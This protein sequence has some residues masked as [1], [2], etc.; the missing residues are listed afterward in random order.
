MDW[1]VEAA[2]T[3]LSQ[4]WGWEVKVNT[5]RCLV[6][7]VA[8]YSLCSRMA[9]GELKSSLASLLRRTL[10]ILLSVPPLR[11]NYLLTVHLLILRHLVG[12]GVQDMHLSGTQRFHHT[13]MSS[14]DIWVRELRRMEFC[15]YFHAM[16]NTLSYAILKQTTK[17]KT[18]YMLCMKRML[19]LKGTTLYW[20]EYIRWATHAPL[21][22]PSYLKELLDYRNSP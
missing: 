6:R 21:W 18:G 12:R 8:K 11:H 20:L 10:L 1:D 14:A 4:L 15:F 3:Y 2:N 22:D 17:T 7:T 19:G 9:K 16:V 13:F 5:D